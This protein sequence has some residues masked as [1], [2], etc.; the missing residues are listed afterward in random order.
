MMFIGFLAAVGT[1][2]IIFETLR[3]ERSVAERFSDGK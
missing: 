2:L 1:G 3:D